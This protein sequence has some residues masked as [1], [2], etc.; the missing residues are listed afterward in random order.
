MFCKCKGNRGNTEEGLQQ[1]ILTGV[2][3]SKCE[4][5]LSVGFASRN[6][7]REL[8]EDDLESLAAVMHKE[9]LKD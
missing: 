7:D 5:G 6:L 2:G 1:M 4:W 8:P 9:C 3:F